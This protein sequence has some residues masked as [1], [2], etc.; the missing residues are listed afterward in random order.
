MRYL[1]K[2]PHE[3][4]EMLKEIGVSAVDDLFSTIPA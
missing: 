1:P 3:R 2:S 4:T